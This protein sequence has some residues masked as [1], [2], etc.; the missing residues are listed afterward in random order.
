MSLGVWEQ[1]HNPEFNS[2]EFDGIKSETGRNSFYLSAKSWIERTKAIGLTAKAGRYSGTFAHRDIAFEF[3]SWLSPELK[4]YLIMEF[5][6][7]K[8]EEDR[9]LSLT[10][11]LNRTLAKRATTSGVSDTCSPW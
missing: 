10:W 8:E 4:L 2:P 6:R 5:Q 1:I 7:L 11:N 9:R 3:G